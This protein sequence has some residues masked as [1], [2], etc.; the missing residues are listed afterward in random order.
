VNRACIPKQGKNESNSDAAVAILVPDC[1]RLQDS[2]VA[3][4][5]SSDNVYERGFT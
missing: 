4:F 2:H 5:L 3:G 1:H